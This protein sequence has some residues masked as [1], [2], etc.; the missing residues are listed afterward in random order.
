MVP[1]E[2]A[3][4]VRH[5]LIKHLDIPEKNAFLTADE[6]RVLFKRLFDSAAGLSRLG[7]V[8]GFKL[9]H[10]EDWN[11]ELEY[12]VK[13][14]ESACAAIAKREMIFQK[15]RISG[16]CLP[17]DFIDELK[18]A[19]QAVR[20]FETACQ[21]IDDSADEDELA[22][23]DFF[24]LSPAASNAENRE[25]SIA[26]DGREKNSSLSDHA[27][28]VSDESEKMRLLVVDD[29]LISIDRLQSHP[30]F[31]KRFTWATLCGRS[32]ECCHC[33]ERE[34]CSMRRARTC[35][36]VV[37]GL[38]LAREQHRK[39][40][41]LLMDVRF[42]DLSSDELVWLPE[43]PLLNSED[44]VKAL[45]GLI[46]ARQLRK[47]PEFRQIPIIL[48]TARSRL[49]D[50][51]A[52]L[53]EG[54]EGLQFVDDEDSLEALA[55]RVESVV[56][57]GAEA[58]IEL[59][60]FWGSSPRIQQVRRQIEIMS[61]GPRTVYIT[62][63]S[64]SGK[65]SLVEHIIYPLSGRH[66]MVTLD[67][68]S[69]PDTLV[70]SE[71]FGHVKGAF[72]G[73]SHDRVGLIEEA[74]GGILFLDEIGNLSSENQRK[75]L[76]FLQDKMVRRVGAAHETRRHVDVKVVVATHLDLSEEVAAGRFRFDLFMRFG[77]AMRIALPP[78][79]E[80]RDDLPSFVETLAL[81]IMLGEEM[82]PHI[83]EHRKR[84]GVS[85][86]VRIDFASGIVPENDEL[87]VRFKPATREL[88][89]DYAW[90]GNT[91]ELESVLDTLILKALYDL[92]VSASKSR[93]IEIDHYYALSL[94]GG[95]E[96]NQN[97]T[98]IEKSF[99]YKSNIYD[100]K[101]EIGK[102]ADFAELRKL[103]EQRY[104]QQVFEASKGD[105]ARMGEMLFGDD[106]A[107]MQHKITMRLNQL[108]LSVRKMK[109]ECNIE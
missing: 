20:D 83:L 104:L 23:L 19:V 81:K 87:C 92:H 7:A 109:R 89:L 60:Y 68:S 46:I 103:L 59:G 106:S 80:R 79:C 58:P 18:N 70:E 2:M 6:S 14:I 16:G 47:M 51:A 105:L 15:L 54:L 10:D 8:W 97:E 52:S 69:V 53:L 86:S 26:S 62:G 57:M 67:L 45:Q 42:D 32:L 56:R 34:N 96:K 1:S 49:P 50:G 11:P 82:K 13:N 55:S 63:P 28:L 66:R 36:E 35:S 33:S 98:E 77:P 85:G 99:P 108:G 12:Y 30:T 107:E 5:D 24:Q 27:H 84:S 93:I 44:H 72:S 76:L 29:H 100:T 9:R 91:R 61:L 88:F 101:C 38:M 95:L 90:P 31:Q 74:D 65:S 78:L 43:I 25:K 40:D 73:A 37:R 48:M 71:L 39:I 41:A 22:A 102:V 17:D 4:R 3:R 75:L 94:I 64:G 21:T